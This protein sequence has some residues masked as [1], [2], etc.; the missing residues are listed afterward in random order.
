MDR[1]GIM[2]PSL[3]LRHAS[4]VDCIKSTIN[5]TQVLM[6]DLDDMDIIVNPS[7]IT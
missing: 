5:A 7:I 6:I 1:F 4:D 2:L 3:E